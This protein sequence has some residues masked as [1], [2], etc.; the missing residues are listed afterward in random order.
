MNKTIF[1]CV[2]A[3]TGLLHAVSPVKAEPRT[4]DSVVAVVDDNVILKSELDARLADIQQQIRERNLP[5]PPADMLRKEV[6]EQLILEQLQLQMA[7]RTGVRVDDNQLLQTM[8]AIAE[9]NG[10]SFEQ[11]REILDSNGL[12]LITRNQIAREMTIN[13]LQQ[14]AVN[15][16]I[17]IT[18]Q[19]IEN[20]LRSEAGISSSNP[21]YHVAHVL[22]EIADNNTRAQRQ[23]LADYLYEQIQQG[24]DIIKVGS[25]GNIG[26]IPVSGGDL[27]WRKPENLPTVFRD[28]VPGMNSGEILEFTSNSGIHIVQLL[29]TRGGANL[30]LDQ[31]RM[32]HIMITPN[33][34]RT[35]AQAEQLAWDIYRRIQD[36][37]DF[38]DL[39]RKN[40]N[41]SSSMVAGGDLGWVSPG[42]YP[43]DFMSVVDNAELG[44]ILEPFR[45]QTGWH[46]VE[47]HERRKQDVTEENK[48]YQATQILRQRKFEMEL[49]NWLTEIR[50]RAY[51]DIKLD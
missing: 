49:E 27:G 43:G 1:C 17:D 25:I 13:Q 31:T 22:V 28:V 4:L 36:G 42:Q 51:V 30:T 24:A 2:L 7:E 29:E 38:G 23:E 37:E 18:R 16:R 48:R 41:D 46:I 32:R 34:I 20:F 11:F 14:R 6:L 19:E 40:S 33:E 12:Y 3:L 39:A 15:S 8:S 50:D 26:G 9:Q 35:E 10:I 47:V 44:V 45:A 21:E 5:A